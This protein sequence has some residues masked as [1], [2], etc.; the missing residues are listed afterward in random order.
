MSQRRGHE[1]HVTG[2]QAVRPGH[3]Q[4]LV[5]QAPVGVEYGLGHAGRA[6]V[7]RMTAMSEPRG[8]T[9]PEPAV[10]SAGRQ[11]A[12]RRPVPRWHRPGRPAACRPQPAPAPVGD[13]R[14]SRHLGRTH[15]VVDGGSHRAASPAGPE[16]DQCLPP[17]GKLPGDHVTPAYAGRRSPPATTATNAFELS[18]HPIATSPSTT[19]NA[20][21]GAGRRQQRVQGRARPRRRRAPVPPGVRSDGRWSGGSRQSGDGP[22]HLRPT[23]ASRTGGASRQFGMPSSGKATGYLLSWISAQCEW[24]SWCR[25]K[26]ACSEL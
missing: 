18:R 3:R 23:L 19:A 2:V 16:Q 7:N 22:L 4:R 5:G 25:V 1:G 14:T 9:G 15:L 20:A 21:A 10:R 26:Q 17:V 12:R 24:L 6:R 8:A 13:T 11:N